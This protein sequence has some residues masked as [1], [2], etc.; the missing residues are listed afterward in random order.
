MSQE[1]HES[2]KV[3]RRRF[4]LG[5]TSVAASAALAACSQSPSPKPAA[6]TAPAPAAPAAPTAPAPTAAVAPKSNQAPAQV[7][8]PP[9]KIGHIVPRSGF[10]AVAGSYSA[11]GANIGLQM[12]NEAGGVLGGRKFELYS[13]DSVDPGVA[14]Q[15]ATKLFE[16]TKVDFLMGEINSASALAE[17]DVAAKFKKL[18]FNTGANSDDLRQAK[19]SRYSFHVESSNSQMVKSTVGWVAKNKPNAKKWYFPVSDYA[20]GQ[21]LYSVAKTAMTGMGGTEIGH[22]MIPT[23]T[24]DFSPF[25]LKIKQMKPDLVYNCLAGTDWSIFVKQY[26]D[27]GATSDIA[28]SQ[29]EQNSVWA[30]PKESLRGIG[31][32]VWYFKVDT[33][34]S[35]KF[36]QIAQNQFGKPPDDQ[37]VKDAVMLSVILPDAINKTGGTDPEKIIKY[38]ESGAKY[39]IWKGRD[40]Y[41]AAYDHQLEQTIY[42]LQPKPKDKLTD[43]WDWLDIIGTEPGPNEP[44]ESIDITKADNV[45]KFTT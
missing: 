18:F 42:V 32:A 8:G 36:A 7:A 12:I 13:E 16:Q 37:A 41:F 38:L 43:Q 30:V 29:Y 31:A 28:S 44:L 35:Q 2:N 22:D 4:L 1:K 40:A 14:V 6:T 10:L 45:C 24:T 33:P 34:E 39:N 19:C 23:G 5:L 15:K 3:T 26:A 17:S 25:I 21:N 9:I 11:M 20:F 27:L